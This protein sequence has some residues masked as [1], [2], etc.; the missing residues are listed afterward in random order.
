[1]SPISTKCIIYYFVL[2]ILFSTS[3]TYALFSRILTKHVNV[4][5]GNLHESL[6]PTFVVKTLLARRRLTLCL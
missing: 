3:L 4:V 1:M 2:P 6:K 5:H